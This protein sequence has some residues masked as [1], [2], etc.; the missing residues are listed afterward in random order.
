MTT[1]MYYHEYASDVNVK[2]HDQ[3][4]AEG[5]PETIHIYAGSVFKNWRNFAHLSIALTI[6]ELAGPALRLLILTN[7]TIKKINTIHSLV[8]I[9]QLTCLVLEDGATALCKCLLFIAEC[10]IR[11]PLMSQINKISASMSLVNSI[12]KTVLFIWRSSFRNQRIERDEMEQYTEI[13]ILEEYQWYH[14]IIPI[15][16][17]ISVI[18][19]SIWALAHATNHR[20]LCNNLNY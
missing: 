9:S 8:Q 15:L 4:P 12:F 17:H 6:F 13:L 20:L 1:G 3:P 7:N 5:N 14:C 2:H 16:C 11:T 19:L 10:G 18:G